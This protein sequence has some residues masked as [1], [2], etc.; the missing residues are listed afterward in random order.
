MQL[1]DP[2]ILGS[3]WNG[4][5]IG[6]ISNDRISPNTIVSY[7]IIACDYSGNCSGESSRPTKYYYKMGM[8]DKSY[9]DIKLNILEVDPFNLTIKTE[10]T[11]TEHIDQSLKSNKDFEGIG[12]GSNYN[13]NDNER[14]NSTQ[15]RVLEAELLG[16]R[17]NYP[18]DSYN[19]SIILAI[20]K[21]SGSELNENFSYNPTPISGANWDISAY[22]KKVDRES[23]EKYCPEK[24]IYYVCQQSNDHDSTFFMVD[25][26]FNR[27]YT[28]SSVIIP[29]LAIFF[30]LGGIFIFESNS[31]NISN[32][33]ALTLSV[34]ALIFSLP[35]IIKSL[36]PEITLGPS[37]ADSLLSVIVIG[38]ISYTISSVIGSKLDTKESKPDT[39]E[40]KI[41]S[42]LSKL[43]T[44]EWW[45]KWLDMIVF[46]FVAI[47]VIGLFLNYPYSVQN[48]LL[49]G[50]IILVGLGYGLLFKKDLNILSRTHRFMS[51]FKFIGSRI[52]RR[53]K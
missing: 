29:I 32:R 8:A 36:K 23:L 19:A 34:F 53:N 10:P 48:K 12:I 21:K 20:P 45:Q 46:V 51:M 39:K 13:S 11:I 40:S 6:E 5:W 37:I 9:T 22:L 25:L 44:K 30:L 26:T 3:R 17:S 27:N 14:W 47:V 43:K 18:F 52:D 1:V 28:I 31:E 41:K 49:I 50:S 24:L 2:D 4:K 42:N 38:A 35:E 7:H 33:L 16:E 15:R